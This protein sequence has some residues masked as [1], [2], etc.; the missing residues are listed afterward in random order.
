[1]LTELGDDLESNCFAPDRGSDTDRARC[2]ADATTF[3]ELPKGVRRYL[4]PEHAAEVDR[5]DEDG[6]DEDHPK[7]EVCS[8]CL[9]MTPADRLDII[10]GTCPDCDL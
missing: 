2:G 4:C 9:K 3:V 7:A 8:V 6:T 5:F 10:D 1:M